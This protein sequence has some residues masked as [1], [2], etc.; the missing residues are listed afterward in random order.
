MKTNPTI[1]KR[2][3]GLGVFHYLLL[4]FAAPVMAA[5]FTV[6]P[7][8]IDYTA[9][10]RDIISRDII[11]TNTSDKPIRAYASVHEVTMGE[12]T[13]IKEFIPS[14][15]TLDRATSITSWLEISR[16]RLE[17]PPRGTLSVPLTIKVHPEAPPG[18][19]HALIGFAAGRNR[20]DIEAQVISGNGETAILKITID[21][22]R[23][24]QLQLINFVTDRFVMSPD[25]NTVSF[26]L[27]NTG[28]VP[29]TPT[30]EVIIY[31]TTGREL[32]AIPANSS[33]TTVLPGEQLIVTETLPFIERLGR[34][35]AYLSLEYGENRAAVFDTTFYYSIPWYYLLGV[36]LLLTFVLITLIWIFKRAFAGDEYQN[37]GVYE[38][39]LFYRTAHD[40]DEYEHDLNLKHDRKDN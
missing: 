2:V 21:D 26:T 40:H 6:S 30:G 5:N 17:I 29:L 31:D 10:A 34:N 36:F 16:A 9:E 39:P 33:G 27:Q 7:I 23:R 3:L 20:D 22:T 28:D 35:K 25:D 14:S 37:D 19:Y 4:S 13:E 15:M 24:T 38:V 12:G 11:L 1:T 8:L 32:A 18:V